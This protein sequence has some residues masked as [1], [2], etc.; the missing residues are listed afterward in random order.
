MKILYIGASG[1]MSLAPFRFLLDTVHE[2]CA[3]G[4][5]AHK[6]SFLSDTRMPIISMQNETVEMLARAAGIAVIDL[7]APLEEC[8]QALRATEPDLMLVSC[9]G[10]KLPDEI[11]A[12]PPLGC[13]NLHPSLLPAYRGP[14]PGFWQFHD[15]V[16][17]FGVSLHRMTSRM[18]AGAIIAQHGFSMSDGVANAQA[19][20]LVAQACVVLLPDFLSNVAQGELSESVQDEAAASYQ[21]FPC[22]SDFAV[23]CKWSARRIF[24]FMR[25]TEHWGTG[26]PCALATATI[27]LATAE[28]F[29][30]TEVLATAMERSDE[31]VKIQCN[32]GVLTA[33]LTRSAAG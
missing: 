30:D 33:R 26:Y 10:R 27:V 18:D 20:E 6:D 3:V 8:V 7:F 22:A 9:F 2:V 24:N 12:I 11:L 1:A 31:L 25:A 15:G 19:S 17:Q 16:T 23:S 29:D 21:S 32:P 4:V 14:V 5:D 28:A 13:F